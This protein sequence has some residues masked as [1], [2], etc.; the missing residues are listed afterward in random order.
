MFHTVHF[1]KVEMP[2]SE[3]IKSAIVHI[4]CYGD[5]VY[6]ISVELNVNSGKSNVSK[7]VV[8]LFP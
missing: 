5:D 6:T 7:F 1:F 8:N 2:K 3:V 4:C